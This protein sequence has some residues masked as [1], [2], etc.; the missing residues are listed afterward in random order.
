MMRTRCLRM[1][2]LM[3]GVV[4]CLLIEGRGAKADYVFGEPIPISP[5]VNN[6][7]SV[8]GASISANGLEIYYD[9]MESA[10]G[11]GMKN[12]MVATRPTPSD[13]WGN[14]TFLGS[15]INIGF[16]NMCPRI[17]ADG[18][19]LYFTSNRDGQPDIYVARRQSPDDP[20]EEAVILDVLNNNQWGQYDTVASLSPNG[21]VIYY[22]HGH[23]LRMAT[24]ATKDSPWQPQAFPGPS[25]NRAGAAISPNGRCLIFATNV[26]P[27]T[28]GNGDLWMYRWDAEA[29]DW[30]TAVNLSQPVNSSGSDIGPWI[31]YDGSTL[32]F[33]SDRPGGYGY[34]DI[35]QADISPV[36]DFNADGML[37]LTDMVMLID[38]WETNN[39]LYDIGPTAFGD[40]I[41][42]IKDLKVFIKHWEEE[43]EMNSGEVE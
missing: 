7:K 28:K 5:P 43:N 8:V 17:S 1:M 39:S 20:W 31:S 37:D 40:G 15:E 29:S 42:D 11:L 3:S 26:L 21:L 27:G 4:V 24:R 12:I 34:T 32:L 6:S 10:P 9:V 19:E 22:Q 25:I 36:V 2:V 35:W 38:N 18:L 13:D 23:A 33:V 30:G 41:V 14:A 16:F